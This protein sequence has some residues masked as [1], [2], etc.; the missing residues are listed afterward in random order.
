M[1][2]E[3]ERSGVEVVI[4]YFK[5]LFQNLSD[6]HHGSTSVRIIG[7]LTNIVTMHLLSKR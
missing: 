1:S 7:I 4:G 5:V 3:D 6:E 2:D